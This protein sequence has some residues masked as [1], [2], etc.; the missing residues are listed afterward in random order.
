[1][2]ERFRRDHLVVGV[3]L[4]RGGESGI[5]LLEGTVGR[6]DAR[7]DIGVERRTRLDPSLGGGR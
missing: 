2:V 6:G 1:M 5:G 3:G 4:E 7:P